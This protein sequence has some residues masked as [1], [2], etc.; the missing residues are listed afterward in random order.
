M[1]GSA[2]PAETKQTD[3]KGVRNADFQ[4]RAL[5]PWESFQ[6]FS[7]TGTGAAQVGLKHVEC[8]SRAG[9]V[10]RCRAVTRGWHM[11]SW[12]GPAVLHNSDSQNNTDPASLQVV[13]NFHVE[14]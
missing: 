1:A 8:G 13:L 11:G 4:S 10:S 7:E 2:R 14:T 5:E 12:L 6:I 9:S 3:Q